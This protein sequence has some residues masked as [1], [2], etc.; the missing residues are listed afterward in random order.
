MNR[1]LK[2]RVFRKGKYWEYF[3][4]FNYD[5]LVL[6]ISEIYNIQQYTGLKDN[7]GKEIY[8]GDIIE[9]KMGFNNKNKYKT[10]IKDVDLIFGFMEFQYDEYS[11]TNINLDT[12]K[13]IGNIY[14]NP[15]LLNDK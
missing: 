14:E 10:I 1:E 13:V 15:E 9:C 7:A 4:F 2:F 11:N 6:D 5:K 8:E 12:I 3:N